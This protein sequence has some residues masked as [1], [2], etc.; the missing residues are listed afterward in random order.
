MITLL[1]MAAFFAGMPDDTACAGAQPQL[2][3]ATRALEARDFA[4]SQRIVEPMQ[5]NYPLCPGALIALGRAYQG[6]GDASRPYIEFSRRAFYK[7]GRLRETTFIVEALMR[8][9]CY[10]KGEL[11]CAHCHDPHPWDASSN[12]T[13]LK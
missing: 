10:R 2:Q 13:S 4:G 12:P 6:Q 1:L 8:T 11:Q 3:A 7:D 5:P 9:A